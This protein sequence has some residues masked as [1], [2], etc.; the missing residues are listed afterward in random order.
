MPFFIYD[1]KDIDDTY[2][3]TLVKELTKIPRVFIQPIFDA[4][5]ENYDDNCLKWVLN[6]DGIHNRLMD[7]VQSKNNGKFVLV[8]DLKPTSKRN[9]VMLLQVKSIYGY[10][11]KE[12]TP[13]CLKLGAIYEQIDV[14]DILKEKKLVIA[15][16][17]HFKE[18]IIEF[19][20]VMKG[21]ESGSLK[22]GMTGSV[23]APLLWPAV[24]NYFIRDCLKM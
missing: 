20:Y 24:F 14:V 4:L 6:E 2:Q 12:W 11:Y 3:Y 18:D 22:W 23:N 21:F 7:Y 8:V 16:K 13:L 1:R 5:P 10:S 9:E 17:E 19:L 15:D